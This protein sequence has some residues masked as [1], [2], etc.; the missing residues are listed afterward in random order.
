V[1][2]DEQHWRVTI[3][4]Y[5]YLGELSLICGLLF[6][7]GFDIVE[8]HVFTYDPPSSVAL[9]LPSSSTRR[10]SGR[11]QPSLPKP[12]K[13]AAGHKKIVDEFT[14]HAGA[15]PLAPDFWAGCR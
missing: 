15:A 5:D 7:Y 3:V 4:G 9:P 8:G 11:R 2:L 14:V 1:A 13:Q 12:P 6:V 10:R